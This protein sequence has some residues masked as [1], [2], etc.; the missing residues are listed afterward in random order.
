MVQMMV[1]GFKKFSFKF[2]FFYDVFVNFLT[3]FFGAFFKVL[4][5][6]FQ[7]FVAFSKFLVLARAQFEFAQRVT[8]ALSNDAH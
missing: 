1:F 2:F 3:R 8:L 4:V 5:A 7:H 6:F